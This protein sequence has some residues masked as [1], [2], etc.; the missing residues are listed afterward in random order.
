[1]RDNSG[2]IIEYTLDRSGKV[3]GARVVNR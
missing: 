2:A 1:V 3:S